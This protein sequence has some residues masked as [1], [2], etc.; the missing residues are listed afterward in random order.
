M[1]TTSIL[2]TA[3]Q[4]RPDRIMQIAMGFRASKAVLSA[5]ELGVF[6]ELARGPLDGE[7]LRQRLGLHPRSAGDF[8]DALVALGLLERQAGLYRNAADTDLYLDAGKASFMGGALEMSNARLYAAWGKLTESLRT[9]RSQTGCTSN[10][11]AFEVLYADQERLEQFLRALN[12]LSLPVAQ[13]L[14]GKLSWSC[15][16]SVIDIGAGGGALIV[17]LATANPH[18]LGG[19]FDLPAVGPAFERYVRE[20]GLS[21]RLRF[22]AGDFLRD[23][24]PSADVLIMGNVLH[25]WDLETKR[26]L[27]AKAH[28]ALPENGVVVV[29]DQMIDDERRSNASG[30]L[31]SL[32]MLIETPGGFDYTGA[33]CAAWLR[34]A[35][36]R[37]VSVAPLCGAYSVATGIK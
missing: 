35:G 24:L 34:D 1:N 29:Y 4:P 18:L 33:E 12:G 7:A 19:G 26:M 5:V 20:H 14:A 9:G 28:A 11:D 2:M 6:T 25:D 17:A 32:N 3:A 23:A 13:A 30:L 21:R 8:F 27:L 22:H 36:F 37:E 16:R 10:G 15:Y 31:M